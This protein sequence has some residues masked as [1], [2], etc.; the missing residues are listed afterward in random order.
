ME[1]DTDVNL[2]FLNA[3]TDTVGIGTATPGSKF[4]V[5]GDDS[6]QAEN[7]A[8]IQIVGATDAN[9]QLRVAYD[10]TGNFAWIQAVTQGTGQDPLALNPDGGN[11]GI[12]DTTPDA[13]FDVAGDAIID[14]EL[15]MGAGSVGDPSVNFVGALNT[16]MYLGST[17]GDDQI[18]FS[19][20]GTSRFTI[21]NTGGTPLANWPQSGAFGTGNIQGATL[22]IGSNTSGNGAAGIL[23]LKQEDDVGSYVWSDTSLLLRISTTPPEEDGTPSDTSGTVVGDQTSSLDSK[24]LLGEF[25]NYAYGLRAILDAP[26]YAFRY[27]S[28]AYNDESFVGIITDYSPIFGKDREAAHPAGKSLNEITALGMTFSAIRELDRRNTELARRVERLEGR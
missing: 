7:A 5:A 4:E 25:T 13:L 19:M 1:G 8:Q 27:R 24:I 20:A 23:V 11:V 28:G 26:L 14:N 3:G 6:G 15:T 16:G 12:G 21:G 17:V 9:K 18:A 22:T 10:T 2:Y